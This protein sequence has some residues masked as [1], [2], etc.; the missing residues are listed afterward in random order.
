[1]ES[2]W[3]M[4]TQEA[5]QFQQFLGNPPPDLSYGQCRI[6]GLWARA[7]RFHR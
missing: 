6:V 2:P 3:A 4:G 5:L 7:V 1:M